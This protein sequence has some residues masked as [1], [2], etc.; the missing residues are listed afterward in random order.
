MVKRKNK[1]SISKNKIPNQKNHYKLLEDNPKEKKAKVLNFKRQKIEIYFTG[2]T[3][4]ERYE[5]SKRLLEL[6][7]QIDEEKR[8]LI[9]QRREERRIIK[10]QRREERRIIREQRREERRIIIEEARRIY[11]NFLK[12]NYYANLYLKYAV[13]YRFSLRNNLIESMFMKRYFSFCQMNWPNGFPFSYPLKSIAYKVGLKIR[14]LRQDRS[15]KSKLNIISVYVILRR[16]NIYVTIIKDGK[17]SKIFS[18]CLFQHIPKKGKKKSISYFYTV[19]R[20]I[21]YI[22]RYFFNKQKKYHLK[23]F[24]KG[25]QKFRRPLLSRF[26]KKKRLKIRCLGISNMDFEPFNG[27]RLRKS[28][29]IKIRGQRKQK[30]KFSF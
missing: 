14:S 24:F 19:K 5:K 10:K 7:K 16:T 23:I 2:L 20:T 13:K 30:N 22:T 6:K 26:L 11:L 12:K 15:F 27:C 28:K 17:L 25:L 8:I 21:M 1:F 29:R 4:T 3:R 18:P 9:E